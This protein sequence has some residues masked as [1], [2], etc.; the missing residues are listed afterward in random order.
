MHAGDITPLGKYP[1]V[2]HVFIKFSES[3]ST[4]D[5]FW[6]DPA[7]FTVIEKTNLILYRWLKKYL[8][9]RPLQACSPSP[10]PFV[11]SGEV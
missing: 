11:S 7:R 10:L 5:F 9:P 8:Y 6:F 2:L 4:F 1:G 3:K